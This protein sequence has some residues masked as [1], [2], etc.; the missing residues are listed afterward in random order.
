MRADRVIDEVAEQVQIELNPQFAADC[1]TF[2]CRR[3]E[4]AHQQAIALTVA[5]PLRHVA[6]EPALRGLRRDVVEIQQV[7]TESFRASAGRNGM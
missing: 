3:P 4:F 6:P 1:K 2:G 5:R 7:E